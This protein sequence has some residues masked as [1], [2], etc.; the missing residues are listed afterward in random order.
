M[1]E[2]Y[3]DLAEMLENE[4]YESSRSLLPKHENPK[5]TNSEIAKLALKLGCLSFGG[6]ETRQQLIKD[7][8][9]EEI[10]SI[11]ENAFNN[12]KDLCLL[13]PGYSSSTFLSALCTVNTQSIC[14][15]IVA[16]FCYNIPSL[17]LIVLFSYIIE[18]IKYEVTPNV[19]NYNPDALYFTMRDDFI[20]FALWSLAAGVA[21]SALALLAISAISLMK[22][23]SNNAFQLLLVILAMVLYMY[24]QDFEYLL[25]IMII[26][27]VFSILRGDHDYLFDV[28]RIGEDEQFINIPFT[29]WPCLLI[30][31]IVYS[32]FWMFSYKTSNS[33]YSFLGENFLK[34]GAASIGEGNVMIPMIFGEFQKTVEEAEVL[35]GYA[36]VSLLPG[37]MLNT[38]SYIGVIT[39]NVFGGVLSG[40]LIFLPGFLFMLAALP[41][42]TKIKYTTGFQF[43]IRGANSGAV[44][45]IWACIVKL[46]FDSCIVNPYT[47]DVLGS[48]NVVLC[49]VL[50]EYM[51]IHKTFVLGLG[52]VVNLVFQIIV[53]LIWKR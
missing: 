17:I 5:M 27:G 32:F 41:Y 42:F 11:D 9:V 43:F 52:A 13:L 6:A 20:M 46:W 39:S 23:L 8:L 24:R 44:G 15:G 34:M 38:A 14:S 2:A 25:I 37:S 29:G 18:I 48:I 19:T 53:H 49:Y 45:F 10:Q 31:V 36:L 30:Y 40:V 51:K 26:A 4:K 1:T 33:I 16:L 7:A 3:S 28:P 50:S 12:I 35:N 21:Q 22:K 47:N